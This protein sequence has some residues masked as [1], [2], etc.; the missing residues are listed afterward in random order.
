M[1]AAIVDEFPKAAVTASDGD[2]TVK[3]KAPAQNEKGVE[4]KI[5]NSSRAIPEVKNISVSF[6]PLIIEG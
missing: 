2:V 1:Q 6:Y 3:V 5:I 4:E